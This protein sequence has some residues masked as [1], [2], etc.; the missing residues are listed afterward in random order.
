MKHILYTIC[1]V[2]LLVS[3]GEKEGGKTEL[4]LEKRIC[5]E[6][7]STSLPIDADIYINLS[8][9]SKFELYQQIGDGCHHLY[10]GSWNLEDGIL[11]GKYNDGESWASSYQVEIIDGMLMLTS[12]ND[13]AEES[14]FKKEEIPAQVRENCIIDVKSY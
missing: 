5:G 2:F 11:S 1:A 8:E 3:C 7:H 9:D 6:W 13:A 12:D 10:R 14:V 4:P